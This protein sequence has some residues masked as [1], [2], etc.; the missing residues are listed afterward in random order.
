MTWLTNPHRFGVA[1]LDGPAIAWRLMFDEAY[2]D[3]T[4]GGRKLAGLRL[5]ATPGGADLVAAATLTPAIGG[6]ITPS[7]DTLKNWTA[8]DG[9]DA[10]KATEGDGDSPRVLIDLPAASVIAEMRH[11][12]S[13][14][15]FSRLASFRLQRLS[16]GVWQ[17]MA[18]Q[19]RRYDLAVSTAYSFP[20][21]LVPMESWAAGGATA[22]HHFWRIRATKTQGNTYFGIR[23]INFRRAGVDIS[24]ASEAG[25]A[26]ARTYYSAGFAPWLAING[27]SGYYSSADAT[28]P[29]WLAIGYAAAQAVDEVKITADNANYAPE[30]WTVEFSDDAITWTTAKTYTGTTGWTTA[31]TRTYAAV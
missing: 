5:S 10:N 21:G 15:G 30:N 3:L 22:P 29:Q 19:L 14:D 31:L 1:P 9:Y 16:S 23:E 18:K 6:E 27:V 4:S 11:L 25:Y 12:V 8:G 28:M 2:S 20:V 17:T 7:V 13:S 24:T 26:F